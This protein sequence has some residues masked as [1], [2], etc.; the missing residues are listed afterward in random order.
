MGGYQA[1]ENASVDLGRFMRY[2]RDF[3]LQPWRERMGD[4]RHLDGWAQLSFAV[5][6]G[7]LAAPPERGELKGALLHGELPIMT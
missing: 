3:K 2:C 4:E 7:L 6:G 5:I 1:A